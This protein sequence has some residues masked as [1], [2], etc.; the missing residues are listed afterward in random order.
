MSLSRRH[1]ESDKGGAHSSETAVVFHVPHASTDVPSHLKNTF[2][3]SDA[4]LQAEII[5]MTDHY[6]DQLV[7]NILPAAA[8]VRFPVSRLVVDPERFADDS[9]EPMSRHGM[10]AIY[11]LTA[12]GRQL[13]KRPS[14]GEREELKRRFY[15]PHHEALTQA[16][17]RA[18]AIHDRCLLIDMHSFPSRPLPCDAD[19]NPQRPDICLG[20][21]E[22]HTPPNLAEAAALTFEKQGFSVEFNRPFAGALVPMDYYRSDPRVAALMVE[23]N[24]RLYLDEETAERLAVF[25]V[26]REQLGEAIDSIFRCYQS[27]LC[28]RSGASAC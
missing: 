4:D 10:G 14:P 22:Y 26:M 6:S 25:D 16:V 2:L 12:D 19:Q 28:R 5:R 9:E 23:V 27:R 24:R 3:L 13:R 7:G 21:D 20:T 18:L 17:G 15:A 1:S 11:Q 8:R